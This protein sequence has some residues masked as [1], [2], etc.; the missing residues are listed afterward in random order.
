MTELINGT[1]KNKITNV[2]NGVE[3]EWSTE[4]HYP[5]GKL[6]DM[7]ASIDGVEKGDLETNGFQ[8]DWWHTFKYD[9]KSFT[10][11]GSGYYGGHGFGITK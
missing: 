4:G 7:I 5:A 11:S 2:L 3:D 9:D 6:V 8:W 10:L 1:I